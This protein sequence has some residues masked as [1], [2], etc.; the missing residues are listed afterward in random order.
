MFFKQI[1]RASFLISIACL[2]NAESVYII[3]ISYFLFLESV[4]SNSIFSQLAFFKP[5][6]IRLDICGES[7]KFFFR[8][9]SASVKL[10]L[11]VPNCFAI[12]TYLLSSHFGRIESIADSLDRYI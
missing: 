10:K 3:T 8:K 12:K 1:Q 6:S 4:G 5:E 11:S 2:F 9:P 7:P